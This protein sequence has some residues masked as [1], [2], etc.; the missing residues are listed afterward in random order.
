MV[1]LSTGSEAGTGDLG[2]ETIVFPTLVSGV[3]ICEFARN[4]HLSRNQSASQTEGRL[5]TALHI[6]RYALN[7]LRQVSAAVGACLRPRFVSVVLLV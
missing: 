2:S 5:C 6:V 4:E 3:W 7:M 1:I